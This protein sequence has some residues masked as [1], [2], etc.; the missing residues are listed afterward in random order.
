[1]P[2]SDDLQYASWGVIFI[3]LSIRGMSVRGYHSEVYLI[4]YINS[5]FLIL[6]YG[7]GVIAAQN[8]VGI[9]EVCKPYEETCRSAYEYLT[10]IR[11]ELTLIAAVSALAIGPQVLTYVLSGL[12]GSASPPRFVSQIAKI[13]VWS[14]IKF[15]AGLGGILLSKPLVDLTVGRHVTFHEFLPGFRYTTISFL[16]AALY[17]AATRG[18]ADHLREQLAGLPLRVLVRIHRFFTR[19]VRTE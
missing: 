5:F 7:L 1:M 16:Y 8:N 10:N 18:L 4:W 3:F 14:L 17:I 6:F 2:T 9:T 12:S 13:A 15:T 11:D 19:N